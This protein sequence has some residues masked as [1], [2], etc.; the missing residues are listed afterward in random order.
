MDAINFPGIFA[1]LGPFLMVVGVVR[2]K[3][4]AHLEE[5]RIAANAGSDDGLA[6][7]HERRIAEMEDRIRVLERIVTDGGFNVASQIEALR[8]S[9]TIE[10]KLELEEPV[11]AH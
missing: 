2:V 9:R 4:H 8:D 7:Q 5:K 1:V 3:S 6:K 11:K 10:P